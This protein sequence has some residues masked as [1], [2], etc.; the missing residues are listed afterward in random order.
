MPSDARVQLWLD[1]LEAMFAS[2]KENPPDGNLK[3]GEIYMV[4]TDLTPLEL[5]LPRSIMGN[6]LF[7]SY[8]L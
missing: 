5:A 4:H 3:S 7:T 2:L 1:D 6:F 8:V